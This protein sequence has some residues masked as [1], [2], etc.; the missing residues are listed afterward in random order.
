MNSAPDDGPIPDHFIVRY[1]IRLDLWREGAPGEL[2]FAA[3]VP[4]LP[5]TASDTYLSA[6]IHAASML[7]DLLRGAAQRIEDKLLSDM[8]ANDEGTQ[9]RAEATDGEEAPEE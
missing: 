3:R 7:P 1:D 9:L 5:A 2:Q 6:E 8:N 4:V